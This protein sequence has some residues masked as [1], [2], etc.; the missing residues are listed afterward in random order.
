MTATG[1]DT[2]RAGWITTE[3]SVIVGNAD[4]QHR[5][6][7][8]AFLD[9]C[10][11]DD[12]RAAKLRADLNP[13]HALVWRSTLPPATVTGA[14]KDGSCTELLA[15][16]RSLVAGG[17]RVVE[18]DRAKP[19]DRRGGVPFVACDDATTHRSSWALLLTQFEPNRSGGPPGVSLRCGASRA[20]PCIHL[21]RASR[22]PAHRLPYSRRLS[23]GLGCR[24]RRD[25]GNQ[26]ASTV[27]QQP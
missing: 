8:R 16:A 6:A 17:L 5:D 9:R 14:L 2:R 15:M 13:T 20:L 22:R 7:L 19:L 11:L 27:S 26:R 1:D 23:A 18:H 25:A 10:R 21:G 24:A 3:I 4:P 12:E